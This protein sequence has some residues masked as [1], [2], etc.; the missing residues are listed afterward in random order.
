MKNFSKLFGLTAIAV[1]IMLTLGSCIINVPDDT[2]N[3]SLNGTWGRSSG[4]RVRISGDSGT[5]TRLGTTGSGFWQDA[6][7]K[8]YIY[9][10]GP[11]FQNLEGNG[12]LRWKGQQRVV[13]YNSSTNTA[14]YAG[15]ADCTISMDEDG[16]TIYTYAS[17][18]T[19]PSSTWTR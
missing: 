8:G 10:N 12:Y 17:G 3:H 5:W 2:P 11:A 15:W 6:I 7:N 4:D 16:K 19:N 9:V 13:N 1:V 14:N 18:V